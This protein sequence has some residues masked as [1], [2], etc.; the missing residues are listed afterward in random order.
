[1]Q[2]PHCPH[3]L[4][5]VLSCAPPG[6]QCQFWIVSGGTILRFSR[7]MRR[8]RL[9]FFLL[10]L[11][12]FLFF[13][14]PTQTGSLFV[15]PHCHGLIIALQYQTPQLQHRRMKRRSWTSPSPSPSPPPPPSPC[16]S[17]SLGDRLLRHPP[18][19][20]CY[21]MIPNRPLLRLFSL[22]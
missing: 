17:A 14:V 15:L 2:C 18:V 22:Y 20:V 11:L 12:L 10:L 13:Q 21:I 1:M 6:L 19:V 16:L 7:R 4:I 8:K 9:I 3:G 5:V